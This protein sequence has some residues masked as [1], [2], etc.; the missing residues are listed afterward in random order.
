MKKYTQ[1]YSLDVVDVENSL[2]SYNSFYKNMGFKDSIEEL[3]EKKLKEKVFVRIMD[4]GCGNAGFLS[5]L[6]KKFRESIHTIGIDLLAADKKPD[7]MI[8][9][10]A[11]HSG[12]PKDID[13]IFSF[14]TLHEV[15]EPEKIVEKVYA[16]LADKGKAF[17]SFRTMDLY[18]GEI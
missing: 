8:M 4:L 3:I 7:E 13:F 17:L 1:K 9:G 5:D 14:R 16:S 6:K 18:S 2:E 12:F 11:L 10:D 15:G